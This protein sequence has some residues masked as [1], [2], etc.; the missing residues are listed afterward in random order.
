MWPL[1]LN[2][3]VFPLAEILV[4]KYKENGLMEAFILVEKTT[5]TVLAFKF[6]KV[7]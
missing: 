5:G 6:T 1:W 7:R 4:R 3:T 2:K